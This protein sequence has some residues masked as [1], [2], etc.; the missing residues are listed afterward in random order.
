MYDGNV[1]KLLPESAA[2]PGRTQPVK[3]S[4]QK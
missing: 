2:Q 3:I 4:V 1:T